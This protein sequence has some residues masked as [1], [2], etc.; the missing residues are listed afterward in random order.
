MSDETRIALAVVLGLAML[1]AFAGFAV[2]ECNA[3][4]RACLDAGHS[5][6]ECR[7]AQ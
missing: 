3:V 5:A 1:L 4:K 7:V 2:K 6:I